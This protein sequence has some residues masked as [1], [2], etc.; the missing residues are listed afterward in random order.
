M[1]M[2]ANKSVAD[3]VDEAGRSFLGTGFYRDSTVERA[4]G[5]QSLGR[6]SF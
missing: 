4:V 5:L 3:S 6:R 1:C 2:I